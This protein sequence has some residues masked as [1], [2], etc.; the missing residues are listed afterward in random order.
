MR[1]A[2][3]SFIA[4]TRVVVPI[5]TLLIA[6]AAGSFAFMFHRKPAN[7]PLYTGPV[8]KVSVG[9]VGDTSA[10]ILLANDRGY[11][12]DYGL[13]VELVKYDNGAPALS[14]LLKGKP[15][16]T[17]GADFIGARNS[18]VTDKFKIIASIAK[19]NSYE[20]LARKDHGITKP[21]DL[22]GKKVGITKGTAGEFW[23]GV[24]LVYNNMTV[25]DVTI[26]YQKPNDITNAMLDGSLD[27][28]L[29][30]EPHTFNVKNALGDKVVSWTGEPGQG[31]YSVLYVRPELID[32]RPQVIDRLL[33]AL[34]RAETDAQNN[35]KDVDAFLAH[36]FSYDEAYAQAVF[37]HYD[38][39]VT[40]SEALLYNMEDEARW[41]ISQKLTDKTSVP[42]YLNF[43]YL[44]G[45]ENVNPKAVTIIH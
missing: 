6:A 38:F 16:I 25:D 36:Y 39:K 3:H 34:V 12:K 21:A 31:I 35:R 27:A 9:F 11:F 18:F 41:M 22:K 7:V 14:G 20:I 19:V 2:H 44:Q 13:D 17:V 10:L 5:L 40:L 15:D 24:F 33:K 42:N 28:A 1:E 45:L 4:K 26:V 29:N 23:L 8:E 32:N 37:P 30:F 43:T